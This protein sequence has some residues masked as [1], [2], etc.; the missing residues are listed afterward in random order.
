MQLWKNYMPYRNDQIEFIPYLTP[1]IIEGARLGVVICPGGGYE[2][3]AEHEGD[4]YARWLNSIGVSAMVLE[5]RVAPYMA[6]APGAD[7]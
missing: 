1:H 4:G 2:K 6:P 7:V 5:Y 3:R